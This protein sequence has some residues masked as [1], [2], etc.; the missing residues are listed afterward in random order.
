MYSPDLT[1][2]R[3][4]KKKTEKN[5]KHAPFVRPKLCPGGGIGEMERGG[6]RERE[7]YGLS[8]QFDEESG[9][10]CAGV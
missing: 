3:K 1:M 7:Y 5:R 9:S 10:C 8:E 2:A 6:E 4:L